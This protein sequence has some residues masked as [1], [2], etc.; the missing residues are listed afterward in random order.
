MELLKVSAIDIYAF[1]QVCDIFTRYIS[2]VYFLEIAACP[3]VV[4]C[5]L[6]AKPPHNR[7]GYISRKFA[8]SRVEVSFYFSFLFMFLIFFFPTSLKH[9][10]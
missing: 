6:L 3:T 9:D 8:P 1:D 7:P 5:S 2:L 4:Y 10:L